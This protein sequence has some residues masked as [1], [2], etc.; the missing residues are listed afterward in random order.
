M[1]ILMK[2]CS[3]AH[4]LLEQRRKKLKGVDWWWGEKAGKYTFAPKLG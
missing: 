4:D 1:L 3:R 2:K